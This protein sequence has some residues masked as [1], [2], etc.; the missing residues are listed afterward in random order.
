MRKSFIL[1]IAAALLLA[2]VLCTAGCVDAP[3]DPIAGTYVTEDDISILYVVFDNNGTGCFVVSSDKP[4]ASATGTVAFTWTKNAD[5]SYTAACADGTTMTAVLNAEHGLLTIG[6]AVFQ[7]YPSG[8]SGAVIRREV[9]IGPE[10]PPEEELMDEASY[11]HT[12]AA[13]RYYIYGA[14]VVRMYSP[15]NT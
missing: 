11:V 6:D 8:Y 7:K 5:K 12:R 15:P 3:S 1:A 9:A 10:D 13:L 2:A 14:D 4:D